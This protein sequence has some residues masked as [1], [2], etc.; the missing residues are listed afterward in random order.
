MQSSFRT[1]AFLAPFPEKVGTRLHQFACQECSYFPGEKRKKEKKFT[2]PAI[3][4]RERR[5]LGMSAGAMLTPLLV[6]SAWF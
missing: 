6:I 3:P 2:C 4:Y 5:H 1:A